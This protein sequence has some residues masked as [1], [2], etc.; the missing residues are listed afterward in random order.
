MLTFWLLLTAMLPL[1]KPVE[2]LALAVSAAD[3][4]CTESGRNYADGAVVLQ[5][6]ENR[7][8]SRLLNSYTGTKWNA[9][10]TPAQHAHGCKWPL[11]LRHLE[12]GWAFAWNEPLPVPEWSR[13]ALWYCHIEPEGTC[14]SRCR[15]GCP[16]VGGVVHT[17]YGRSSL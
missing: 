13:K 5:V 8:K 11:T 10:W 4:A 1:S 2:N 16:S 15:G 17:F 3:V 12:L 6:I 7:T 9:L 14:E